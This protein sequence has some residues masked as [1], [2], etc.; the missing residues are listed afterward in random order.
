MS[1]Y[2][3]EVNDVGVTKLYGIDDPE[4]VLGGLP[5]RVQAEHS[6]TPAHLISELKGA[7][8]IFFRLLFTEKTYRKIYR[9]YELDSL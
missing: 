9:L 5:L 7:E 3:N 2:K 4:S 1:R 6:F 8:R